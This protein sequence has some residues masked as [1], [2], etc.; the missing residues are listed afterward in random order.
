M[1]KISLSETIRPGALIFGMK[2]DLVDLYPFLFKLCPWGQNRPTPCVTRSIASFQ[3]IHIMLALNKSQ[4]SDLGPLG[5]LVLF[6]ELYSS[7]HDYS[8]TC[9]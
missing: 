7:T 2:Y 5:P 4:M 3:Q 9:S 8:V 1:K 6:T